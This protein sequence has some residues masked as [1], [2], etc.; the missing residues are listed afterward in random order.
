MAAAELN[1]ENQRAFALQVVQQLRDSGFEALWAGGCVRDDLLG[2]TPGDYDVAT[3]AK[4]DEVIRVFGKR[5]TVPVGVSFG[6]VM[7]LGPSK[8]AGQVE[9]ATFR[10]D[11][12]YLDGRR[13][14]EVTFC[15][16]EEDAKR[17]DFT[18]NGMFFDPVAEEVIDYV[19]GRDDLAARVVR[20][21]GRAEDRF[22]EDKLR[23]LRAVRF[24]A[25]FRFVLEEDTSRA[26]SRFADRISQ[27][28]MER[29]AAELRRMLAHDTRAI[30]FRNLADTGLL[31]HIFP[32]LYETYD[33]SESFR[34]ISDRAENT[35]KALTE[36]RFEASLA[37]LLE[38]LYRSEPELAKH[39][40]EAVRAEC[41]RLKLSNDETTCI[42]WIL[43]SAQACR[44]APNP[45]LHIIKPILADERHAL[46]LDFLKAEAIAAD[47][48][49]VAADRLT[50][51]RSRTPADVL[52]PPPLA[53]G[54]DLKQLN[55]KP[56]PAFKDLLNTIRREQLDEQ[57]TSR[58]EALSRLRQLVSE[59][60]AVRK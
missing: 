3:S 6:V 37:A 16:A 30:S 47:V 14:S 35:L 40:T 54:S 15:S 34:D 60:P 5:R 51:Y 41:R 57:I 18:I 58:E 9:V 8:D 13:P 29:I 52:N 17:R 42:C 59:L 28:S 4:P 32:K 26:V 48:E 39:R 27:V 55:V 11:G 31:M 2:R 56:G 19:G 23:M 36:P 20:A 38:P 43:D 24:A 53:D 1:P 12:E 33:V 49:P 44:Q 21:I 46:L 50:E 22:E 25:T 7:V 45:A 10:A